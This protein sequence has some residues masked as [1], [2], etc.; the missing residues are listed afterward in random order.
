[1]KCSGDFGSIPRNMGPQTLGPESVARARAAMEKMAKQRPSRGFHGVSYVQ[2]DFVTPGTSGL[3][4]IW[5]DIASTVFG[6]D[7]AATVTQSLQSGAAATVKNVIANKLGEDPNSQAA[8]NQ[9]GIDAAK[10]VFQEYWYVTYPLTAAAIAVVGM[11]L[12][13]L[14]KNLKKA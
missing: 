5:S 3:G 7:G 1:M 2:G 14:V 13:G 9:T 8:I 12:F 11:G 10:A 6:K 4:D